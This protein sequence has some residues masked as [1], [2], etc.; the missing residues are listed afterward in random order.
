MRGGSLQT[1]VLAVLGGLACACSADAVAEP[2]P[3]LRTPG[4]FVA[5]DEAGTVRLYR[6]LSTLQLQSDLVLM[7][8]AYAPEAASFAEAAE[9][10]RDP[11]LPLGQALFLMP[12]SDFTAEPWQVV[13][14]RSPTREELDRVY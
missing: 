13:W 3:T 11:E 2:E 14:F 1:A 7:M 10:A 12:E 8:E 6:T 5:R 4:A 9:L